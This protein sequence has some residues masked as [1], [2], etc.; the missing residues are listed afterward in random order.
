MNSRQA[1]TVK[2]KY[3]KNDGHQDESLGIKHH[4]QLGLTSTM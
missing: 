3:D 2:E 1:K 4:F